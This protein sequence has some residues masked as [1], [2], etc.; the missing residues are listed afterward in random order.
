M[1]DKTGSGGRDGARL[2]TE[3]E[4]FSTKT[5]GNNGRVSQGKFPTV[6]FRLGE[7]GC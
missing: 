5:R 3:I 1:A 4:F 7:S 6:E 2:L